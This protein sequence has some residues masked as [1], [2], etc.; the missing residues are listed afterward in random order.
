MN[1]EQAKGLL[2]VIEAYSKG[3]TIQFRP[4]SSESWSDDMGELAFDNDKFHYRIK[5]EPP[6]ITDIKW[7]SHRRQCG[8]AVRRVVWRSGWQ[9]REG[10]IYTDDGVYMGG[11]TEDDCLADDWELYEPSVRSGCCQRGF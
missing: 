5:P 2:P 4:L 8:R 3:H 10:G 9:W 6:A 1:R 11:L 7:A